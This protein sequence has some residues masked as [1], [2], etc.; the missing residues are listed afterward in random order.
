MI[1]VTVTQRDVA[2]TA[3]A[4][5]TVTGRSCRCMRK[6]SSNLGR[7]TKICALS[8]FATSFW[9]LFLPTTTP[10]S[11]HLLISIAI[12]DNM[13]GRTF[14]REGHTLSSSL[15]VQV[16]DALRKYVDS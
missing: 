14:F 7:L 8:G 4:L 9:Q 13:R 11:W 5:V 12:E 16:A 10:L 6:R 1:G 15:N 3:E 2:R